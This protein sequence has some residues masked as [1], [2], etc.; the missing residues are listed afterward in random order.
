[1]LV[2]TYVVYYTIAGPS[3]GS[4]TCATAGL[5]REHVRGVHS[6]FPNFQEKQHC[7][8]AVVTF[9]WKFLKTVDLRNEQ[10]VTDLHRLF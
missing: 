8:L 3:S 4:L 1:M 7:I 10:N 9:I 2:Q 5:V 6:I